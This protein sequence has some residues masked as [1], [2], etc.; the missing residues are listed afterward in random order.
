MLAGLR[1][2]GQRGLEGKDLAGERGVKP[3]GLSLFPGLPR[4]L[5]TPLP[6]LPNGFLGW[7]MQLGPAGGRGRRRPLNSLLPWLCNPM[8]QSCRGEQP[9]L[10]WHL[11]PPVLSCGQRGLPAGTSTRPVHASASGGLSD[12]AHRAAKAGHRKPNSDVLD[13]LGR[14][15]GRGLH[16]HLQAEPGPPCPA[17]RNPGSAL[18]VLGEKQQD[19]RSSRAVQPC[20]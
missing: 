11:G 12:R 5:P 10:S 3:T 2:P 9:G 18:R 8:R 7:E 6:T 4:K 13:P 1:A 16:H 14:C 15:A 17:G 19:K 20:G